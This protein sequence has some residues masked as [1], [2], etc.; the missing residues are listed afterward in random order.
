MSVRLSLIIRFGLCLSIFLTAC[1]QKPDQELV[2][3]WSTDLGKGNGMM[4]IQF[5]EDGAFETRFTANPNIVSVGTYRIETE[6][7]LEITTET[8]EGGKRTV[9]VEY[10]LDKGM[11]SLSQ[12]QER[13]IFFKLKDE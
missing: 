7:I 6:G 3:R 5:T 4:I 11:L 1:Q 2:G 13:Q 12:N 10:T 8:P 9:K